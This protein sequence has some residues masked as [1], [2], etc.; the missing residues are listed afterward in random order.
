MGLMKYKKIE[1]LLHTGM[2]HKFEMLY[3]GSQWS[4]FPAIN[5]VVADDFL[6]AIYCNYKTISKWMKQK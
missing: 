5:T 4:T 3:R 6:I 2:A 1:S